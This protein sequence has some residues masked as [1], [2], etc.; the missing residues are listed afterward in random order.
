MPAELRP[1]GKQGLVV[2]A[3]GYGCMGLSWAYDSHSK[4]DTVIAERA[5]AAYKDAVATTPLHLDTGWIC[6]YRM[7]VQPAGAS[8]SAQQLAATLDP[9][10]T[11]DLT[12]TLC[13]CFQQTRFGRPES[14][15]TR[16]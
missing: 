4:D 12:S 11:C 15:T 14:R 3:A 2:P 9:P 6:E 8:A 13:S 10:V 16:S 1:L 7:C 5:F